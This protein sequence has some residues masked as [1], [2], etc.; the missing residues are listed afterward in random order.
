[1]HNHIHRPTND[2]YLMKGV[3]LLNSHLT[4]LH[5]WLHLKGKS[6]WLLIHLEK[7]GYMTVSL[8]GRIAIGAS[9]SDFPDLVTQATCMIKKREYVTSLT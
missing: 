3:G 7:Y 1:M 2:G 4:T 5:H 9:R 8:V 6:R